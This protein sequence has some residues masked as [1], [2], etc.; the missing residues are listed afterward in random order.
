M[1]PAP[2]GHRKLTGYVMTD[3]T[4]RTAV[5]AWLS[6]ATSAE[7]T[8]GHIS[9]WETGG[10][11]DMEDLF[12][13]ASSFNE[14]IS[15]WDI[16]GVTSFR[17]MFKG[18]LAFNQTL[19]WC[20]EDMEDADIDVNTFKDTPCESTNCGVAEQGAGCFLPSPRPTQLK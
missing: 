13:S 8:Y 9:T 15:A 11:T 19:G 17:D 3:S 18:A 12:K 20:L 2:E 6:D 5:A 16:S 14:D 10:V 7:A 1:L 4:I